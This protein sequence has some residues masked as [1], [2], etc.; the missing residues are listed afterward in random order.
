[1]NNNV[2]NTLPSLSGNNLGGNSSLKNQILTE[3]ETLVRIS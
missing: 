1:M 2:S 3:G